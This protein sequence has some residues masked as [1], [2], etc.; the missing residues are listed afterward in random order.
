MALAEKIRPFTEQAMKIE[1]A[2]WIQ[3]YVVDMEELY[4][5]LTLEKVHY[6]LQGE[7]TI[8]VDDYKKLFTKCLVKTLGNRDDD[9][10]Y[11]SGSSSF[12]PVSLVPE[13]KN[14]NWD[15]Y[16]GDDSH[17]NSGSD[18][19]CLCIGSG[20]SKNK[21]KRSPKKASLK[22]QSTQSDDIGEK[23]LAKGDPGMGKTTWCKKVAWDWAKGLF[24]TM[25]IV[26]FV[27][28]KLVKPGATIENIIIEQNLYMKGLNISG[29]RIENII[30]VFG[31]RCLL[32]LDG[33]DEQALGINKDVLK[34]I[35]GEKKMNCNILVTSRPHSTKRIEKYFPVILRVEGFTYNKAEQFASKILSDKKSIKAVLNF[36]P[37]DFRNDVPIHKCPIL[38]SFLCLLVRENAIDLSTTD[39]HVGEIYF[40]MVLC[41]Y[42]KFTIRKGISFEISE[43]NRITMLIGKLAY[44]TLLSGNPLLRRSEVL[45]EVGPDAFDYGLLIGHEDAHRLIKDETADIYITFSH[46]SIQEFLGA[47][48][49]VWLADEGADFTSVNF[50]TAKIPI[51][52]TDPLFLKFC[53]WFLN[54]NDKH[55]NL[56]NA[57]KVYEYLTDE[58]VNVMNYSHLETKHIA[59]KYPALDISSALETNDQLRLNFCRDIL[60]KCDKVSH[61]TADS[62]DVCEWMLMTSNLK[63]VKVFECNE[64]E[65][66]LSYLQNEQKSVTSEKLSSS[67]VSAKLERLE[68]I[69]L[70]APLR[71]HLDNPSKSLTEQCN[72]KSTTLHVECRHR[73]REN[74]FSSVEHFDFIDLSMDKS[75]TYELS[76]L[77]KKDLLKWVTHLSLSECVG[78]R[79]NFYI[80]FQSLLPQ[81]KHLNLL[82]T[83][84]DECDLKA[85]CLACNGNKKTLPNLTSLCLSVPFDLGTQSVSDNL[86]TLPWPRLKEFYLHTHE[87]GFMDRDD[88]LYLTLNEEK[89]PNLSCIGIQHD[90]AVVPLRPISIL[91]HVEHLLLYNSILPGDFQDTLMN[92]ST[93]ELL[94]C[95]GVSKYLSI[96]LH[97]GTLSLKTLVLSNCSLDSSNL[98]DLAQASTEGR[99]PHLKQLY[100]HKIDLTGSKLFRLFHGMSSWNKLIT[101]DIRNNWGISTDNL[102]HF[103]TMVQTN[104]CL[105]S[106]QE[107]GIDSYPSVDTVWPCLK[108]LYL[109]SCT[110]NE[111]RN[112]LDGVKRGCFPAFRAIC[113]D[114]FERYDAVLLHDLLKRNIHCHK[115]EAP[116]YNPFTRVSCYCQRKSREE[117]D[118]HR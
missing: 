65:V 72:A 9:H 97:Q 87:T 106:L 41:L 13:N 31:N 99:L 48:F 55:K 102:T 64:T 47:F 90:M 29:N 46:R 118:I 85:L 35:R 103:M 58:C 73:Y 116:F 18:S 22:T 83:N 108:S 45:T 114:N 57:S 82:K 28:L 56:K 61:I 42:K 96:F 30:K 98:A 88:F 11:W 38:L 113:V 54:S 1:V 94:S 62:L 70:S 34:I 63:A 77:V 76:K 104:G 101:L 6:R 4:T 49:F 52:L 36:N 107:L 14:S 26:F 92:F 59:R 109:S 78:I 21:K 10:Q 33:L 32:I 3:D 66:N 86:A 105:G 91:H 15:N 110:T 74:Q 117:I 24:H 7:K 17:N 93:L 100:L 39:M 2:P 16:S 5:E 51:F 68:V 79:G 60:A 23:I 12:K 37:Q 112:I 43:F 115:A 50:T 20:K 80:F 89:L 69:D 67:D 25:S 75:T 81:L 40:R 8:V 53:L 19:C 27:F 71:L 44:D 111:L 84:L 95:A